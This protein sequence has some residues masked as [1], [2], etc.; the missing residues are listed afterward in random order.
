MGKALRGI[1]L[2]G[3]LVAERWMTQDLFRGVKGDDEY[4]L[5]WE[6]GQEEAS[7]RLKVHR[8]T[9][10]T[11]RD[12]RWIADQGFDFVRLPVGYWLLEDTEN[13]RP[14]LIS[15]AA[16]KKEIKERKWKISSS[17]AALALAGI[18]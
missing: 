11:Q 7:R 8:D 1:N 13:L 14:E 12:F 15:I 4:S 10:I 5:G 17:L 9:F 3:W 6:L 18:I 2:G 16:P